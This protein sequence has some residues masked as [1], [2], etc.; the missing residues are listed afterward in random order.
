MK[1]AGAKVDDQSWMLA[2]AA[3]CLSL[4]VWHNTKDGQKGINRPTLFTEMLLGERSN[5]DIYVFSSPEEYEQA[6]KDI[7]EGI[8]DAD[9]R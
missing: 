1:L 9:N 7:K 4:L 6:R 3:D 5:N 2:S 8:T